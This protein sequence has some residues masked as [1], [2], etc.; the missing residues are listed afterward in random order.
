MI[1]H[2]SAAMI[3]LLFLESNWVRVH[4]QEKR[5]VSVSSYH[6]WLVV[7]ITLL[8]QAVVAGISLYCFAIFSIPWLEQFDI[9]RG[10]LTLALTFLMV[11][12]G[13]AAP[14]I[15]HR[16]DRMSLRGPVIAGYL[17]FCGGLVLL[18]LA[19]AYWQIIV[20]YA[21]FLA[22]GQILS[23]TL[24]SQM[25][26]NRWFVRDNGLALGISAT[27]TSLG[28]ILFPL[29][30][31]EALPTF[32]LPAVFQFLALIIVVVLIPVNYVV[33]RIQTPSRGQGQVREA[34]VVAPAPIWTTQQILGSMAFWIP[35]IVLLAVTTSFVAIQANL[36]AHLNDLD[37]SASFTGQMIAVISAMMIVGK[38]LYGKLADRLDHR[39]LLF[40]MGA[41]S[42]AAITLLM[43]TSDTV[44]LLMA[45]VLLGIAS[46]GLI[47]MQGAVFVARFGLA[48]FGKV[49]G[50]VMLVMVAGSLG[51]VYAAWIYDLAGSYHYAFVSFIVMTMPGLLLLRW[52]PSPLDSTEHRN[53]RTKRD[54]S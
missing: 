40:F 14:F 24:V 48:T 19:T 32:G 17:L 10:Q 21:T 38:L 41:M 5:E 7:A 11:T 9:S 34:G 8:N 23:G 12:N 49:I 15:G 54:R 22:V 3:H 45:A 46:G 4:E 29:L 25:L 51:S 16:L 43:S 1:R 35:L 18:S 28:G 47:P 26:I 52:L 6:R 50:L 30:V 20:I 53:E 2:E 39:Y 42:I 36:G 13:L 31:A 37:Y 44:S 33:L 27:G